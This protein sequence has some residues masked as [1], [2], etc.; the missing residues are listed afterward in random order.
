M[1]HLSA[2]RRSIS[3]YFIKNRVSRK[4]IHNENKQHIGKQRSGCGMGNR[5]ADE[6]GRPD[7]INAVAKIV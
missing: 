1:F 2:I 5:T 4:A 3:V 7:E 6:G